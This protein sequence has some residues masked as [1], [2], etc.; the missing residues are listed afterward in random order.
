MFAWGQMQFYS[1]NKYELLINYALN[2]HNT[3]EK[4]RKY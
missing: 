2:T 1:Y 4:T 3:H